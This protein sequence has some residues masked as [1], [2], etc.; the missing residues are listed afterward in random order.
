MNDKYYFTNS[1]ATILTNEGMNLIKKELEEKKLKCPICEAPI[2]DCFF[3]DWS[4]L[5]CAQDMYGH[6][7]EYIIDMDKPNY[8]KLPTI[9][10][11]EPA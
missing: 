7:N 11:K 5:V 9:I 6:P 8:E 10:I 3:S 1:I 2:A 4:G